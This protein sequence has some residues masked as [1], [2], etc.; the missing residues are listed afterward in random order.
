MTHPRLAYLGHVEHPG[1]PSGLSSAAL[2][3]EGFVE[4]GADVRFILRRRGRTHARREIERT[5]GVILPDVLGVFAPRI[6]SSLL[7][8]YWR[9]YR[10]L[11]R[12]DRNVVLFRDPGFLPWAVRLGRRG[13]RVFFEAHAFWGEVVGVGAGSGAEAEAPSLGRS[14]HRNARKLARWLPAVDGVFCTSAPLVEHYRRTFP[15]LTVESALTGTRFPRPAERTAFSHL[16]GYFGSLDRQH[17]VELVVEGL[18]RC[19]TR[20]ARLLVV[21]ARDEAERA[22]LEAL[23]TAL[24]VRD[25]VEIH[26]W[27]LPGELD[28]HATRIDVGVVPLAYSFETR[29]TTPRK[30]VDYLS[31]SLPT[32]A[33][34]TP[35]VTAYVTHG[36]EALLVD[37]SADSW[38]EAID[39]I[40]DDFDAYRALSNQALARARELTW[41]RRAVRMLDRMRQV[42]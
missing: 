18:S 7:L 14:A 11:M 21:G 24:G 41:T 19:R 13:R 28:E 30:L 6:G 37:G 17:P 38:A 31:R 16:L 2:A 8:Y 40:Y 27:V 9:V 35:A 4:A 5:T 22:R 32:I 20:A 29:T 42:L 26:G 1:D 10:K 33:T 39:R 12:S 34:R 23:A 25:R 3:A 36:R 15:E